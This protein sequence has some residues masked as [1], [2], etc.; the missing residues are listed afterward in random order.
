MKFNTLHNV[1]DR[2]FNVFLYKERYTN[3]EVLKNLRKKVFDN[4]VEDNEGKTN[5][6]GKMTSW[7]CF[8]EDEDFKIFFNSI[9]RNIF[10]LTGMNTF[11]ITNAW[12]NVLDK[13]GE[14]VRQHN[15][16][17]VTCAS[18]VLHLT[19]NGPG[20]YF[21]DFDYTLQEEEGGFA[22]FSPM[23]LHEVK[24]FKYT[25]PRVSIAF[26]IDHVYKGTK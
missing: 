15:H 8:I 3:K 20:L 25:E 18:G 6:I 12:G 22:L 24:K 1:V 7:R 16:S 19:N 11:R 5:V 9:T 10:N 13:D 21:D 17:G 23:V 14:F 4:L 2:K 26:N